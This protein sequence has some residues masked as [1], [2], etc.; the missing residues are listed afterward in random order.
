VF[1]DQSG[2]QPVLGDVG[3]NGGERCAELALH[4]VEGSLVSG[5]T[6]DMHTGCRET[7]SDGPTEAAACSGDDGRSC[8]R[9]DVCHWL[10]LCCVY[11]HRLKPRTDRKIT[12]E[13][14][15]PLVLLPS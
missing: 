8:G 10:L 3:D 7:N 2:G 5:D 1:G 15:V 12:D 6:D 4:L 11:G 9:I 13:F 14:S